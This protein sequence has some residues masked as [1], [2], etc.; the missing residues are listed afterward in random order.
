MDAAD[1]IGGDV[2]KTTGA[3]RY[4]AMK[5][6]C[7]DRLIS[8]QAFSLIELVVATM[9]LFVITFAAL[10]FSDQG[11]SL[12][13]ASTT[14]ATINQDLRE[15][16]E[17]MTRQIRVAYY[18]EPST[19]T[20]PCSSNAISF[21]SFAKGGADRY[22]VAYRLNGSVLQ[23]SSQGLESTGNVIPAKQWVDVASGVGSL[24]I[25][26]YKADGTELAV[27]V[28]AANTLLIARVEVAMTISGTFT[29]AVGT[30]SE[31]HRQELDTTTMS[32]TGTES[33]AIRNILK[34]TPTP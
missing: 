18:F 2:M 21:I 23:T 28:T 11:T 5:V 16:L 13:K 31:G 32:A 22:N 26:Y 30:S 17:A 25:K 3:E 27:P 9:L 8:E 14:N 24:V 29:R 1:A 10:N 7:R 33:V 34:D 4:K 12:A 20:D 19:S 6:A 15:S